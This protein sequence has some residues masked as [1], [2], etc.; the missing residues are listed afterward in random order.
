[1]KRPLIRAAVLPVYRRRSALGILLLW[2]VSAAGTVQAHC[3]GEATLG[4]ERSLESAVVGRVRSSHGSHFGA[5]KSRAWGTRS[6]QRLTSPHQPPMPS[7]S[8]LKVLYASL[9]R[10]LQ[11]ALANFGTR[12]SGL[13]FPYDATAPPASQG[14]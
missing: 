14:A 3:V 2:L 13:A 4:G 9:P 1:M 11:P 10:Q 5:I 6:E 8:W 7:Q 12:P